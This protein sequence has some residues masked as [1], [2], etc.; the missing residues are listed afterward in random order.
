MNIYDSRN[1]S[2]K[3]FADAIHI[4]DVHSF[5][6]D[7]FDVQRRQL[8]MHLSMF[9]KMVTLREFTQPMFHH[10]EQYSTHQPSQPLFVAFSLA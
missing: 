8:P 4:S 2:S 9:R 10:I 5:D 1:L 7:M 6:V 3:A